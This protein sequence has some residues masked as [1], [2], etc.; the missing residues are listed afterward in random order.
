MRV[1]AVQVIKRLGL[2][3]IGSVQ[4]TRVFTFANVQISA[5]VLALRRHGLSW[6]SR[7]SRTR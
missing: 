6:A 5:T 2:T 4:V 3:A 7:A 1:V